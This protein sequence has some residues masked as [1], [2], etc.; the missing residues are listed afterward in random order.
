MHQIHTRPLHP[1]LLSNNLNH[2]PGNHN[3]LLHVVPPHI[4]IRVHLTMAVPLVS[5]CQQPTLIQRERCILDTQIRR[6]CDVLKR[7]SHYYV[8]CC[9]TIWVRSRINRAHLRA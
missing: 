3:D 2:L 6:L 9:A 4:P 5:P 7:A 8:A 1:S